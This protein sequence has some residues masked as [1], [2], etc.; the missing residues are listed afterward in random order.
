M[1]RFCHRGVRGKAVTSP[2]DR[3]L[4]TS[5]RC[6]TRKQHGLVLSPFLLDCPEHRAVVEESIVVVHIDRVA[7]VMIDDIHRNPLTEVRL[8]CIDTRLKKSPDLSGEPRR[9]IR[10]CEVDKRHSRLP[11]VHLLDSLSVSAHQEI[12]LLH[13]FTEHIRVL[14]DIRVCPA[15]DLQSLFMVLVNNPLRFR[16]RHRIPDEIAPVEPSEPVA[17]KVEHRERNIPLLHAFHQCVSGLLVIA[18]LEG[19][20]E[21]QP[22]APL[23]RKGR[24]SRQFCID[25]NDVRRCPAVDHVKTELFSRNG[26]AD[27][28]HLLRIDLVGN[29]SRMVCKHAIML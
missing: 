10:V 11:V 6:G 18:R 22:E 2:V 5:C 21:P 23:R 14:S 4:L 7:S 13:A 27:I 16:K 15:A 3:E 1:K 24:T 28:L 9:S 8:D 26:E 17:V 29:L 12:P 20:R 25:V 19:G